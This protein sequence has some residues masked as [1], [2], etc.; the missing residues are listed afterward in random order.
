MTNKTLENKLHVEIKE[1]SKPIKKFHKL[2]DFMDV[3]KD[4]VTIL[5]TF[6]SM[7]CEFC[8]DGK[9]YIPSGSYH[10]DKEFLLDYYVHGVIPKYKIVND[11]IIPYITITLSKE[12]Y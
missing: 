4:G 12:R 5:G 7:D 2:R 9:S 11:K 8:Y 3:G 10:Y 6:N 1:S